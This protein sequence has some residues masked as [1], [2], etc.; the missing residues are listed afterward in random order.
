MLP[1]ICEA[2]QV[3]LAVDMHDIQQYISPAPQEPSSCSRGS[4][5]AGDGREGNQ[6]RERHDKAERDP[7]GNTTPICMHVLFFYRRESYST[8]R[9]YNS[10][11]P[12]ILTCRRTRP[13]EEE[14]QPAVEASQGLCSLNAVYVC[15]RY[16]LNVRRDSGG[17][18][19]NTASRGGRNILPNHS[20]RASPISGT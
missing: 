14:R 17:T 13:L 15:W 9:G 4:P 11:R 12:C 3:R 2:S 6:R 5:P 10:L 8:R 1:T 19:C 20:R 18:P 7:F 16:S